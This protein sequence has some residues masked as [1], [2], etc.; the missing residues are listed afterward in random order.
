MLNAGLKGRNPLETA[1]VTI[2]ANPSDIFQLTPQKGRIRPG[3]D[4][5]LTLY[6]PHGET[7]VDIS[8]WQSRA[9]ETAR[10]W[11]GAVYQGR[12]VSTIVRGRVVYEGGEVVGEAG[13][14]TIMRAVDAINLD[15]MK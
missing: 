4:A 8:R 1:I 12:G 5:D 7:V 11:D 14:G 3:A 6:D 2:T 10:I 15:S 9:R 13:F